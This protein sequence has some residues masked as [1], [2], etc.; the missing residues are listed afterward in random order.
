MEVAL[1]FF[2]NGF[3]AAYRAPRFSALRCVTVAA[4]VSINQAFS[5][6]TLLDKLF[7]VIFAD[8]RNCSLTSY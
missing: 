2:L 1:I 5:S 6:F 4:L 8:L 3:L 7:P